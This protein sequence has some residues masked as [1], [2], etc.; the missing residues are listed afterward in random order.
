[1]RRDILVKNEIGNNNISTNKIYLKDLNV[2]DV[3]ILD[4]HKKLEHDF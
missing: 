1:M 4:N 2:G 3:F